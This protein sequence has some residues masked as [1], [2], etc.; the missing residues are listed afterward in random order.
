MPDHHAP[1]WHLLDNS[2]PGSNSGIALPRRVTS[3]GDAALE[4]VNLDRSDPPG[5]TAGGVPRGRSF[6]RNVLR[7]GAQPCMPAIPVVCRTSGFNP[8]AVGIEWR[9]VCR[10][11]LCRHVNTGGYRY[12]GSSEVLEREWRGESRAGSFTVFGP[13]APECRC[14]YSD[15]SRVLGGHGILMVAA[16][17][18]GSTLLDYVH[19]RIGGTNPAVQDVHRYLDAELAGY[20]QNVI[21]MLRAIYAHEANFQQFAERVQTQAAM[22]FNRRFHK[23]PTQ[24]D[25]RVIFDWP[26]DPE[27][28]PLASFDFGVG[29]SQFTKVGDQKVTAEIAWDW[30]EN[31][32]TSANLFLRKLKAKA[33]PGLTWKHWALAAW[34][35]Y[36]GSGAAAAL[37]AKKLAMSPEG[38]RVSMQAVAGNPQIALIRAPSPLPDPGAWIAA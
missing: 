9:L 17:V 31:I 11:V 30:R 6:N 24:P 32:R 21:Y 25:C 5:Y 7:L 33:K 38:S 22:T 35:S 20:D 16:R 4:I 14:T 18:N 12:R 8:A 34:E 15:E 28:F 29:I 1:A 23:D 36:N 27:N 13:Q 3:A 19:L 37:Y 26:D 10:H 2:F